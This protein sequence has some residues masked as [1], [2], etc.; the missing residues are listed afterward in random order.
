MGCVIVMPVLVRC[1]SK[2]VYIF[3]V[4]NVFVS[5]DMQPLAC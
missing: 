1:V 3:N 5:F 4:F 2:L